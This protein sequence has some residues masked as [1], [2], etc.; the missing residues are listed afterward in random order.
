LLFAANAMAQ[1]LHEWRST[2]RLSPLAG[3][4]RN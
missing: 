4:G 3:R 2:F 1:S